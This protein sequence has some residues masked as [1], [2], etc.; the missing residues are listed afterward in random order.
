MS[1]PRSLDSIV[2]DSK[3]KANG[4]LASP[5]VQIVIQ[6]PYANTSIQPKQ[7]CIF[8]FPKQSQTIIPQKQKDH[9]NNTMTDLESP[10]LCDVDD[11]EYRAIVS[12][13]P[14][15]SQTKASYDDKIPIC[16]TAP[17]RIVLA[18]RVSNERRQEMESVEPL[19]RRTG[20]RGRWRRGS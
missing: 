8:P 1:K 11:K 12:S 20:S 5:H 7:S 15:E 16:G 19:R 9:T 13:W 18:L 2:L 3:I 17:G 4:K 6:L 14:A 10:K